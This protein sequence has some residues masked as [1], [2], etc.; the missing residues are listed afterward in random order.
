MR[1]EGD[2]FTLLQGYAL[3]G[4][5]MVAVGTGGIVTVDSDVVAPLLKEQ[6]NRCTQAALQ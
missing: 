3:V 4:P 1:L 2:G 6:V 5:S